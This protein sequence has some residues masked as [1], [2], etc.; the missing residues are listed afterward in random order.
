MTPLEKTHLAIERHLNELRELFIP[1]AEL[2]FI[3]RVPDMPE[4]YMLITNDDLDELSKTIQK[5]KAKY[6]IVNE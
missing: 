5:H 2:T 6:G 1:E 3:M 4:T